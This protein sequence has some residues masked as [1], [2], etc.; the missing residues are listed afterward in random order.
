[1]SVPLVL[2]VGKTATRFVAGKETHRAE[3]EFQLTAEEI[4]LFRVAPETL[5]EDNDPEAA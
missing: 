1:M 3:S 4:E 5:P 2:I